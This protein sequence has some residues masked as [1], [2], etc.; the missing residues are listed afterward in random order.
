MLA[1]CRM[2]AALDSPTSSLIGARVQSDQDANGF[3]SFPFPRFIPTVP[4]SPSGFAEPL[5]PGSFLGTAAGMT[6]GKPATQTPRRAQ[7]NSKVRSPVAAQPTTNTAPVFEVGMGQFAVGGSPQ[8]AAGPHPATAGRGSDGLLPQQFAEA[9][10]LGPRDWPPSAQKPR[11]PTGL[12]INQPLSLSFTYAPRVQLHGVLIHQ[13]THG[14][15]KYREERARQSRNILFAG[16]G[17]QQTPT[18]T[19]GVARR[20]AQA[21]RARRPTA[22]AG[23]TPTATAGRTPGATESPFVR[24]GSPMDWSPF[25]NGSYAAASQ[26][27]NVTM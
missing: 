17:Y 19:P 25:V 20:S 26:T 14:S 5:A 2:A 23:R 3:T 13:E 22:S 27:P 8:T 11:P 6:P 18:L 9:V 24:E 4:V 10:N 16:S 12:L 21:N 7:R 15:E 1:P